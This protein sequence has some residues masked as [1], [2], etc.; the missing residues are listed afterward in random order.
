MKRALGFTISCMFLWGCSGGGAGGKVTE[1]PAVAVDY[2][3][4][5]NTVQSDARLNTTSKSAAEAHLK[6]GLRLQL[7]QTNYGLT[8]RLESIAVSGATAASSA[9]ASS[10]SET[11]VHI[12][13]VDEADTAKYDGQYWFWAGN[14]Q[15]GMRIFKA[16]SDSKTALLI[17]EQAAQPTLTPQGLYLQQDQGKTAYALSLNSEYGNISPLW[18]GA[19]G[20]AIGRPA[21]VSDVAI[22]IAPIYY[23]PQNGKLVLQWTDVSQVEKP[24]PSASLT[25]QGRLMDSRKIGDILYVFTRFDPWLDELKPAELNTPQQEANEKILQKTALVDLM[26]QYHFDQQADK[27][28]TDN[29]LLPEGVDNQQG[30][31]SLVHITAVNV[32][33]KTLLGST[34]INAPMQNFTLNE[35]HA[36]LIADVPTLNGSAKTLIHQFSLGEK[37]AT[38]SATGSVSGRINGDLSFW[39]NEKDG[40]V[41]VLSSDFINQDTQ[42]KITVL[43]EQKGELVTVSQLPNGQYPERIGKPGEQI[44]GARFVGDRAYV[45]TFKRTDP[46]YVVDLKIPTDPH[47]IGELQVPGFA[48]YLHPV[49]DNYLF[50]LGQ[51]ADESGRVNGIKTELI[52]VANP[53]KPTSVKALYF[54]T[55]GSSA[56]ALYDLH[57]VAVLAQNNGDMRFAFSI[58]TSDQNYQWLY[59]GVYMF[60]VGGVAQ[61]KPDLNLAGIMITEERTAQKTYAQ[62]Y[63]NGRTVLNTDAV[64]YGV[65]G[66]VWAGSWTNPKQVIGPIP[67]PIPLPEPQPKPEPAPDPIICTAE[68]RSGINVQVRAP[69]ACKNTTLE[70]IDAAYTETLRMELASEN[71]RDCSFV[72]AMERPGTY[73]VTAKLKG[74]ASQTL[75]TTVKKDTCHVIPQKLEIKFA[76]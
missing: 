66:T 57:A 37:G 5:K 2:K 68:A 63:G 31:P 50:T 45:V 60:A 11:N 47:I 56:E 13:G 34:C 62:Y 20:V 58:N 32:K 10:F 49:G 44:Y 71:G 27:P 7:S 35:K 72:G 19:P 24:K 17:S 14:Y 67:A 46:L 6:N 53:A 70:I 23:R 30:F 36:F 76:L 52:D 51:S 9:P 41:R 40:F 73:T 3:Q 26:P 38:Y 15:Q 39:L 8:D 75:I 48:T 61:N 74:F 4:L 33:T 59:S 16:G 54:G 43:K 28:L 21:Q 29:C 64:Y 69:N 12:A 22:N 18:M 65:G 55:N 42:H 25:L 1:L